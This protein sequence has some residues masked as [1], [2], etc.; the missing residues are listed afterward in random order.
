MQLGTLGLFPEYIQIGNKINNG[1]CEE[2]DNTSGFNW[3]RSGPLLNEA[4]RAARNAGYHLQ[5][6]LKIVYHIDEPEFVNDWFEA[7]LQN[8]VTN[9]DI[10]GFSYF[11][12]W[13]SKNIAETGTIIR[14]LK[15]KFR[16]DVMVLETGY[17]WTNNWADNQTNILG[18][19]SNQHDFFSISQQGQKQ[20]L[21]SLTQTVIA[22]GGVGLLYWEPTWLSTNA[23]TDQGQ[24]S[25][26][27]NA[28]LFN[29]FSNNEATPAIDF[30]N[31]A[32]DYPVKVHF[33]VILDGHN[34]E[35]G[36]FVSGS[37][38]GAAWQFQLMQYEGNYTFSYSTCLMP[39]ESHDYAFFSGQH[40]SPDEKEVIPNPCASG[41]GNN[42]HFVVGNQALNL[43]YNYGACN[44]T[45]EACGNLPSGWTGEDIGIVFSKG[46][47]CYDSGTFT[48][49]GAGMN[50]GEGRDDYY[51]VW[52]QES[53]DVGITA[54][55]SS[56]TNNNG[57]AFAGLMMRSSLEWD[58]TYAMAL[59]EPWGAT[60]LQARF[61]EG[62]PFSIW[63]GTQIPPEVKWLHLHRY[64]NKFVAYHSSDGQ[65]WT[66]T[67]SIE[68]NMPDTVYIGLAVHS[69]VFGRTNVAEF[70]QVEIGNEPVIL[71]DEDEVNIPEE[72]VRIFPNPA[73]DYFH[74]TS[75]ETGK[76]VQLFDVRG[77]LLRQFVMQSTVH[78]EDCRNLPS[79]LYLIKIND[80]SL[81]EIQKIVKQ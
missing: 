61:Q 76:L 44:F 77:Q 60:A 6:D 1:F 12:Q 53:G 74:I 32:Y 50:M 19:A 7:A 26:Y 10:I 5:K 46:K 45:S 17:P 9:F 33:I 20:F 30:F 80:G 39:G 62:N 36:V 67:D 31:T 65:F 72:T 66:P 29:F 18:S 63:T 35:G 38:T 22:S 13:S 73:S 43:A 37:F 54:R 42:R 59:F 15:Y 21:E 78:R 24:G 8:E 48:V 2:A 55:I 75:D 49:G 28:A 40:W 69:H 79:G 27:E 47:A 52:Q 51:F 34:I 81:E 57:K 41:L 3:S 64:D 4:S 56:L 70:E 68:F 71:T 23:C 16:R 58:A 11:P 14:Q 25:P